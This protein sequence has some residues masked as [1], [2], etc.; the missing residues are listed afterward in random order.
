MKIVVI[1]LIA[2]ILFGMAVLQ[3]MSKNSSVYKHIMMK[4]FNQ[5]ETP[6]NKSVVILKKDD[7][8]PTV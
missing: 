2:S 8:V 7:F 6:N 5:K 1:K 3:Y 4:Q